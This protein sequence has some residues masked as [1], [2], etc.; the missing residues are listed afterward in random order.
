MLTHCPLTLEIWDNRHETR[1]PITLR[2]NCVDPCNPPQRGGGA[3]R[4]RGVQSGCFCPNK[5][6]ALQQ[7]SAEPRSGKDVSGDLAYLGV[8]SAVS[9][10]V[11]GAPS[12]FWSVG[13]PCGL[14]IQRSPRPSHVAGC[15]REAKDRNHSGGPQQGT[16]PGQAARGSSMWCS[17][18]M[19]SNDWS[20][21]GYFRKSL[22]MYL[23]LASMSWACSRA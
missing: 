4:G 21:N 19:T 7:V 1:P 2:V 3:M 15:W 14:P 9:T 16:H 13:A 22:T 5:R 18:A 23:Y 11:S 10:L 12:T 17:A 20:A 6:V 8:T